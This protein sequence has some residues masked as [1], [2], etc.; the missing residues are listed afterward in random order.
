[1]SCSYRGPIMGPTQDGTVTP[2]YEAVAKPFNYPPEHATMEEFYPHQHTAPHLVLNATLD[3]EKYYLPYRVEAWMSVG[4][5]PIR[6]NAQPEKYVEGFKKLKFA[7]AIAFHMDEP[8]IL[9][10]VLLPEHSALE[11]LRVAPFYPQHQSIDD[12]VLKSRFVKQC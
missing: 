6:Q 2:G 8:A 9:S 11:R 7:V 5:N 10:D 12:A 4:G 1:M 3:P